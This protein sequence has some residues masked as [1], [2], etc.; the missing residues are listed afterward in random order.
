MDT[1]ISEKR[2]NCR[3]QW[4]IRNFCFSNSESSLLKCKKKFFRKIIGSFLSLELFPNDK[5]KF[6]RVAFFYFASLESS[7]LKYEKFFKKF[8]FPKH[9]KSFFWENLTTFLILGLESS[10]SWSIRKNFFLRKYKKF[11]PSGFL[12]LGLKVVQVAL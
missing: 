5:K 8:H 11:F 9:K 1:F 10:V 4:N 3:K 12:G 7:L 2:A 6:F